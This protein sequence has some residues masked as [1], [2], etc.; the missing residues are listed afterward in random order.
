MKKLRNILNQLNI[1]DRLREYAE[2]FKLTCRMIKDYVKR[3]YKAV[4]FSA[5]VII[6]FTIIYVLCPFDIIPGFIPILGQLDDI[7]IV[8]LALK[9][10]KSEIEMYRLWLETKELRDK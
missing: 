4:S 9:T 6:I 1:D 7:S 2:D 10:L 5:K 8:I 3:D